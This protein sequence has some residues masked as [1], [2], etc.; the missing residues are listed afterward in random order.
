MQQTHNG[1]AKI[2]KTEIT[3]YYKYWM[4]FKLVAAFQ[5]DNSAGSYFNRLMIADNV[6]RLFGGTQVFAI[7]TFA[8][9]KKKR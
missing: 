1:D 9:I 6:S 3:S 7:R 8:F 5:T 2:G 4:M